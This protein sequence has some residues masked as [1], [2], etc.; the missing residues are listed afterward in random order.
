MGISSRGCGSQEAH[1]WPPACWR[2]R[3][4]SGIIQSQHP[5]AKNQE[6]WCPRAR[7][8]DI[9]VQEKRVYLSSAFLFYL[10]PQWIGWCEPTMV[11]AD[12]FTQSTDSDANLSR[13]TLT[14]HPGTMLY[15]LSGH[16][17]AQSSWHIKSTIIVVMFFIFR[18]WHW[19]SLNLNS[20]FQC[21]HC[22]I[23]E[24]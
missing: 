6:L 20:K 11:M 15:Q 1:D 3:K 16:L 24:K 14:A 2:T 8:D 13:N 12:L 9:P 5:K 23:V 21:L 10:V 18:N 19:L 17:L 22:P 7:E 4:A